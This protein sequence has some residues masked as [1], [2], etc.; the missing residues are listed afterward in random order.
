MKNK[1]DAV[2]VILFAF[3]GLVLM[4]IVYSA[5]NRLSV[6]R[7]DSYNV[8]ALFTDLKQL[9]VGDDVRVAGVRVGSVVKTYLNKDLAVAVLN[10]EK[11]Y[12]IPENS[13][14]SILMAGLLGANYI[15]IVP[16]NSDRILMESAYIETRPATD[17]SSVIQKFSSVGDRLDRIL[18]GFD[19]SSSNTSGAPSL[20]QEIGDF[21]HN[22]KEK[23][24]QIVDNFSSITG[25][26]SGGQGTL[27]KLVCEDQAYTDL[28]DM[29]QSIKG[30][31]N[32]VDSMLATF[33]E[34]SKN[35]KNGDGLLGKLISDPETAKSFDEIVNNVREFSVRLNN[36]ESTLGR[37]ISNDDLY[38]KAESALNKVDKAVDSV[39]NSGPVTAVGVVSSALF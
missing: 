8:K 38:K 33:E 6:S 23:L 37:I 27:G 3:F 29:M 26:I 18:S 2:R 5:L 4:Y 25:K 30:A 20:F 31:A 39:S 7:H 10:I 15:A 9:Q 16:G 21:F 24:N 22:N 11:Q 34:I 17:I 35:I 13:V 14:A 36:A 32:K 28:L 12:Q 19:G 1:S